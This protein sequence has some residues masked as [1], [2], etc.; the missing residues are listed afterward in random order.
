MYRCLACGARFP[1]HQP[2]CAYCFTSHSLALEADR[3]RS[4]LD[5]EVELTDA[6]T[7]ARAVWQDVHVPAYSFVVKRGAFVVAV[8]PSGA[9]KSTFVARA[10]D[11]MRAPALLVSVEEPGGPSL[12]LRLARLGIKRDDLLVCSRGSVDQIAGIVRDRKVG[13]LA[14]DSIQRALFEPRDLRHLLLTLPSLVVLFATSQ[15]NKAGDMRGAEELRHE[16]DVVLS[17][18]GMRWQ[19]TKS[20]Y[21][22]PGAN[23]DVLAAHAEKEDHAAAE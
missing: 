17:V 10:L 5:G 4:A 6:R 3:P 23:G 20:R 12:A 18:E 16:A 2:L 19:V 1:L 22:L 9:G 21:E 11:S 7:L 14:I 13:A 15:I 8:G